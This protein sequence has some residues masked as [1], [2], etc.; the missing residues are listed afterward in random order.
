MCCVKINQL[1]VL[2]QDNCVL[3]EVCINQVCPI[4][5][6]FRHKPGLRLSWVP[7]EAG[8]WGRARGW[9]W[10][11][12]GQISSHWPLIGWRGGRVCDGWAVVSRSLVSR[13]G[14]W[15]QHL[16]YNHYYH[17]Y[18]FTSVTVCLI[19]ALNVTQCENAIHGLSCWMS[20]EHC[21]I[22]LYWFDILL[23]ISP[24]KMNRVTKCQDMI[25][26]VSDKLWPLWRLRSQET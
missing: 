13:E 15:G 22:P 8:M 1:I 3:S 11:L 10:P 19:C 6:T 18:H 9:F 2:S 17:Y 26:I 21:H 14:G 16:D 4:N 23:F 7:A 25:L 20:N 5:P 12:I 24:Q